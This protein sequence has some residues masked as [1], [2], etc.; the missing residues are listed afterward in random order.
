MVVKNLKVIIQSNNIINDISFMLNDG[1]KIGLVGNNGSG[2]TT[3]LKALSNNLPYIGSIKLNTEQVDYLK[4]EISYIYNE[5]TVIQYIKQVIGIDSLENKLYELENNLTEDNMDCYSDTLNKYLA[6]DGYNFTDNL[7]II[8]NGLNFK[9]SSDMLIKYLSGGEKIK[10]LLAC[11]LLSNKD[12]LLL[13][14]PTNNLDLDAINWLERYLRKSTKKMI[15]VSHDEMFLNSIVNKIFE[16]NNGKILEYNMK[17]ND[18]LKEKEKEY[19]NQL[20]DYKKIIQ[21]RDKLKQQLEKT[22]VWAS[23]GNNKKSYSD[24]DKIA[25]N[26]A[27]ERTNNSNISKISKALTELEIPYFKEKKELN[28]FFNLDTDK[29]NKD[30]Y[31]NNLVCGCNNFKTPTIN[32]SIPYGSKIQI[33]GSNGSGKTTLVRTILNEIEPLS[34]E[35]ILGSSVKIGYISQDTLNGNTNDTVLK[36]L[37]KNIKDY[38]LSMIFT[39]LDKFNINYDDKD[40][41][42]NILSPGQRTRVNLVKIALSRINVL[43]LDEVTNH[44]D[45]EAIDLIYELISTYQGTII[46]ISHNRK[47][48]DILNASMLIDISTGNIEY[49]NSDNIKQYKK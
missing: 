16:L 2:K 33:C 26:Y 11:L 25:N 43:I 14:E 46:S 13:D 21:K 6:L 49:K 19:N 1:D 9:E 4:Q 5:L 31:L 34:G 36:Y 41:P 35:V 15:I 29:G 38:D 40:K 3:L 30:I 8:L 12:I 27:K 39:L 17:Y 48:N 10:I 44:L 23:K 37:T 22:K 32:I 18:Y 24:N 47:Y 20:E 42:Y 45:K 7:N 28:F